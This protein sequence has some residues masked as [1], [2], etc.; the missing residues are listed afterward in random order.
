MA[1]PYTDNMPHVA[2]Y[3][4]PGVPD[5]F[6]GLDF[7]SITPV[8]I[9]CRWQDDNELFRDS[10]SREVMS[11]AVVYPDQQLELRG[12]LVRGDAGTATSVDPRVIGAREIRKVGASPS[13][14]DELVLNKVWL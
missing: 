2:T 1:E 4:A 6:G 8:V 10:S 3:W 14:C 12:M 13:L 5:Q 9:N 7:G 11:D